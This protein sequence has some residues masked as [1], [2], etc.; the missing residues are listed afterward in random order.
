[1]SGV[2]KD[3]CAI[4]ARLSLNANQW[5]G[6]ATADAKIAKMSLTR[7]I[8]ANRALENHWCPKCTSALVATVLQGPKE[9][10]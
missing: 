9:L 2:P 3:F 7:S 5:S 6:M 4:K 1:M 10:A 8:R